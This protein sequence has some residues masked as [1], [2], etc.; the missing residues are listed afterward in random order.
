MF[1]K[2]TEHCFNSAANRLLLLESGPC[3]DIYAIDVNYHQSCY[4]KFPL[5]PTSKM[6][7]QTKLLED[8]V[9]DIQRKFFYR[10]KNKNC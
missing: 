5:A 2:D 9:N 1:V 10:C 7:Q 4:I 3:H 6:E 8:N